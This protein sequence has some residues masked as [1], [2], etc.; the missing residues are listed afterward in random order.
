MSVA[1]SE[2]LAGY[3]YAP[4]WWDQQ[5]RAE[6]RRELPNPRKHFG[7]YVI[8]ELDAY[9]AMDMESKPTEVFEVPINEHNEADRM[10]AAVRR[11]CEEWGPWDKSY[12]GERNEWTLYR[13][14]VGAD[15]VARV[16]I[17]RGKVVVPIDRANPSTTSVNLLRVV[18]ALETA[19]WQPAAAA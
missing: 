10:P 18:S 11:M 8:A 5:H 7:N 16:Q 12:S 9:L 4:P 13:N 15:L 19:L 1:R 14:G 6:L 3:S 17:E 2:I